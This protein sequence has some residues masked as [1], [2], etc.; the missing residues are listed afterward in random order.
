MGI[1]VK[2]LVYAAC[3]AHVVWIVGSHIYNMLLGD[4]MRSR[5]FYDENMQMVARKMDRYWT[6]KR[7][8]REKDM[9]IKLYR[10]TY[11]KPEQA[12]LAFKGKSHAKKSGVIFCCT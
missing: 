3:A 12:L 4:G 6:S 1:C 2:E 8:K 11:A 9:A 7:F 5:Y 10:D